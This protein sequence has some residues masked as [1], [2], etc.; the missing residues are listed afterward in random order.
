MSD[1]RMP[2]N[3]TATTEEQLG[4]LG[5]AVSRIFEFKSTDSAVSKGAQLDCAFEGQIRFSHPRTW[6]TD[7]V[8][9]AATALMTQLARAK[10]HLIIEA[11]PSAILPDILPQLEGM[12]AYEARMWQLRQESSGPDIREAHA[13]LPFR[14]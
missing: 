2:R 7:E 11:L 3:I 6:T 8:Q 10:C 14:K 4:S 5:P 13:L 9:E 12:A 1:Q